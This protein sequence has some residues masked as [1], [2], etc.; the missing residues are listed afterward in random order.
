M[1]SRRGRKNGQTLL[2][3]PELFRPTPRPWTPE[4]VGRHKALISMVL[5]EPQLLAIFREQQ[6]L[7]PRFGV[8]FDERV[9]EVPWLM[10]QSLHGRMLDA[11]STLNQAHI[12]DRL[13]SRIDRLHVVTLV[14]EPEAFTDRGVSYVYSDLRDLPYRDRYFDAIA[15]ISTLEHVG[16]DNRVYGSTTPRS[17]DPER[18]AALALSE[19][20]RVLAPAG[21]LFLTVPYGAS[22]DHGWFRQYDRRGAEILQDAPGLSLRDTRVFRY[23]VEGWQISNLEAAESSSYRDYHAD[24][25]PVADLAAAARAVLCLSFIRSG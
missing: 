3:F 7:P 11:G 16:M 24:P 12:L 9:V 6:P 17:S 5:D 1:L 18:E 8:S 10:A 4:Y 15:C 2:T 23:S 13:L 20:V 14:P 21:R 25:S 19:L 22:E